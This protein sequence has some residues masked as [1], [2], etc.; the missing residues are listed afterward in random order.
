MNEDRLPA[1]GF[2]PDEADAGRPGES[3]KAESRTATRG[4]VGIYE[5]PSRR[6]KLSLPLLVILILATLISLV[7][8]IRFLF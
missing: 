7:L 2:K 1:T 3:V 4:T 6:A 5:R 8:S